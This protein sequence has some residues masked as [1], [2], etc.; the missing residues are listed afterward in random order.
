MNIGGSLFARDEKIKHVVVVPV[1]HNELERAGDLRRD[2]GGLGDVLEINAAEIAENLEACV[3]GLD[4]EQVEFAGEVDVGDDAVDGLERGELGELGEVAREAVGRET[5]RVRAEVAEHQH[6]VEAVVVE[7]ADEAARVVGTLDGRELEADRRE[8]GVGVEQ[9][10]EGVGAGADEQAVVA[11]VVEIDHA[12]RPAEFV[13]V[14]GEGLGGVIDELDR[15]ARGIR[16]CQ[17]ERDANLGVAALFPMPRLVGHFFAGDALLMLLERGLGFVR[18]AERRE[19]L[20]QSVGC[21]EV[22]CLECGHLLEQH[23][24]LPRHCRQPTAPCRADS[25]PRRQCCRCR[26]LVAAPWWPRSL[27]RVA[28][29]RSRSGNARRRGWRRWPALPLR[30]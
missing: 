8:D 5:V 17:L 22:I 25:P 19:R 29:V 28:G 24:R 13:G 7:V 2:A 1:V 18:A 12:E 15:D 16:L 14:A 20:A 21:A 23:E 6:V 11:V 9:R 4:G 27:G 10:A 3:A 26:R 30:T